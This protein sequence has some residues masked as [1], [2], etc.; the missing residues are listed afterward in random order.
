MKQSIFL[1]QNEYQLLINQVIENEGEITP[2]LET[3]LT[4]NK[5]QL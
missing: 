1:I 3:A 4:I 2:E 5:E